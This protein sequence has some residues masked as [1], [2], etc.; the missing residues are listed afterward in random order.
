MSYEGIHHD[1]ELIL[2]LRE[3][4]ASAF[5]EI[6]Q[7]Y[8][9]ALLNAAFKRLQD[10]EQAQDIVQNIFTDLWERKRSLEIE[11]LQ[12]YLH[13]AV[14]FQVIKMVSRSQER[15]YFV[16]QLPVSLACSSYA[17]DSIR[18]AEARA[19]FE[20]WVATLPEKRRE[21]FLL[22]YMEGHNTS[23]IALMLDISQKTVQNQLTTASHSLK[24]QLGK[25]LLF[26]PFL[27]DCLSR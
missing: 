19:L 25:V 26:L 12:A 21:I 2:L 7:R 4:D 15:S 20:C 10:L 3:G 5:S 9:K 24:G 18:E 27:G 13:T 8:W 1:K 11:N 14:R 16:D 23:D 6:Y 17:D 22:H